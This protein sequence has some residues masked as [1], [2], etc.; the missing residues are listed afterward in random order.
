MGVRAGKEDSRYQG[1][2]WAEKDYA[3]IPPRGLGGVGIRVL[4]VE[5]HSRP[6]PP[7]AVL[8]HGPWCVYLITP[9]A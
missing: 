4:L 2:S 6:L 8:A 3:G 1:P 7:P 5:Q 9:E